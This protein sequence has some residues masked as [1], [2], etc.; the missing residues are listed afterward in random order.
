MFDIEEVVG[1]TLASS[2]CTSGKL[3]PVV[4]GLCLFL[5]DRW[6][7]CFDGVSLCLPLTVSGR[8]LQRPFLQARAVRAENEEKSGRERAT[9]RAR[10]E[11]K[12]LLQGHR[13]ST[14][15]S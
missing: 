4:M 5:S 8:R 15:V 13:D 1:R 11:T 12:R 10:R 2:T 3:D 14:S 7:C 9:G 6:V